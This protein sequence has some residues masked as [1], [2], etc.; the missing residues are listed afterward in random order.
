MWQKWWNSTK[1]YLKAKLLTTKMISFVQNLNISDNTTRAWGLMSTNK[2]SITLYIK[3]HQNCRS[4]W[5]VCLD[6]RT[7]VGQNLH[8]NLNYLCDAA[9]ILLRRLYNEAQNAQRLQNDYYTISLIVTEKRTEIARN[10][11]RM[12][13]N[14][15]KLE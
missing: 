11:E 15:R 5:T 3:L 8:F 13:L 12:L 9:K 1:T 2:Q 14:E 6:I 4:K 7:C 10:N